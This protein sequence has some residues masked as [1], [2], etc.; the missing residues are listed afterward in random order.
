MN[1]GTTGNTGS[2]TP[3]HFT[4]APGQS[5]PIPINGHLNFGS[6]QYLH[7]N[8]PFAPWEVALTVVAA[9]VMVAVVVVFVRRLRPDA[10]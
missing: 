9:V 6:Y 4:P 1:T 7:L 3:F 2:V 5:R 8:Q 10:R